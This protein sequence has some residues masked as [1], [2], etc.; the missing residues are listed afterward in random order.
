MHR[1]TP[2]ASLRRCGQLLLDVDRFHGG[3]PPRHTS[4][5]NGLGLC[6]LFWGLFL[7]GTRS[8]GLRPRGRGATDI[9]VRPFGL[10]TGSHGLRKARRSPRCATCG[11]I[12]KKEQRVAKKSKKSARWARYRE[13]ELSKSVFLGIFRGRIAA[14]DR[15]RDLASFCNRFCAR[16]PLRSVKPLRHASERL[17]S[18]PKL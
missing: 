11:G 7:L 16:E 6:T 2:T 3:V 5:W 18:S 4:T 8:S 13:L 10:V 17:I 12:S 15:T 1:P 9:K 14:R